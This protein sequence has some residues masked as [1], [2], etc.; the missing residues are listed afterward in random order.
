ML[1]LLDNALTQ[2]TNTPPS[3]GFNNNVMLAGF[4]LENT[5]YAMQARYNLLAGNYGAAI[6]A[7]NN[8]DPTATS[9][10]SFDGSTSRN[11]IFDAVASGDEGQEY[12]PAR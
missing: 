6:D 10:F 12:A 4:D 3:T 8:V 1:T 7:A 9:V 11:P 5:I 2:I